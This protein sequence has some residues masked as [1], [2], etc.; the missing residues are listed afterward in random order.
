MAK[1]EKISQKRVEEAIEQQRVPSTAAIASHPIH[2]MLVNFPIGLLYAALAAD[3]AFWWTG[4]PFWARG[5][6]WLIV[7]GLGGG[8]AAALS[9]F[10]DF[11]TIRYARQQV[12]GW[13]HF[14]SAVSALS[15]A[16]ANLLWRWEDPIDAVLPWGLV[17]SLD[18]AVLLG[19]AGWL[20]GKLTFRHLIGSYIEEEEK[21]RLAEEVVKSAS[22]PPETR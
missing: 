21:Q 14:L 15:L 8:L 17:L 13:S 20:G 3:L 19:F 5:A 11:L 2:P 6:F 22:P 10:T 18:T 4:D 9:G 12:G 7:G 1:K 16:T